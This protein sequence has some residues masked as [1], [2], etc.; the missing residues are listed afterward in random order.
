[1]SCLF[2]GMVGQNP[3]IILTLFKKKN[4]IRRWRRAAASFAD[5]P[6]P[7]ESKGPEYSPF[8]AVILIRDHL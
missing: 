4:Q 2:K 6:A 5:V 7:P 1:M 3:P 8:A